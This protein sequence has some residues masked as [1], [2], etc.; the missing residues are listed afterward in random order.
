[1]KSIWR[2]DNKSIGPSE[3]L[4]YT[5]TDKANGHPRTE[6]I[7]A[8]FLHDH[9]GIYRFEI[10]ILHGDSEQQL[11]YDER[12]INVETPV[13]INLESIRGSNWY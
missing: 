10:E 5:I 12:T 4:D 2:V 7:S 8:I 9:K 6:I 1:M 13:S 3:I 11:A